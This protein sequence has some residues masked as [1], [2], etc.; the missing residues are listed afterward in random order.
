MISRQHL[1]PSDQARFGRRALLDPWTALYGHVTVGAT[2]NMRITLWSEDPA[3]CSRVD[4]CADAAAAS[5]ST[6]A[7]GQCLREP[8]KLGA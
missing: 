3:L 1:E 6:A 8:E 7:G 4:V 2:W 5:G